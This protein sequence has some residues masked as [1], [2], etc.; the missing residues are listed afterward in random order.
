MEFREIN[1]SNKLSIGIFGR[2][3]T[4]KTSLMNLLAEDKISL[5]SNE[6]TNLVE[7]KEMDLEGLGSVIIVKSPN[8]LDIKANE[9]SVVIHKEVIPYIDIAVV[10]FDSLDIATELPWIDFMKEN[11]VIILPVITKGDLMEEISNKSVIIEKAL[12]RRPIVISNK[13]KVYKNM[14]IDELLYI[15]SSVLKK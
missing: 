14:I 11:G 10:L 15:K 1:K 2:E 13:N 7:V 12:G 4:G 3:S 8:L 5:A 6:K 9:E